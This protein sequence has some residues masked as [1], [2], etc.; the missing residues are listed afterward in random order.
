MEIVQV[1]SEAKSLNRAFDVLL[2]VRGRVGDHSL[3]PKGDK[4]TFRGNYCKR[5]IPYTN[6][7]TKCMQLTENLVTNVVLPDEVAKELL[8]HTGLVDHLCIQ[9]ERLEVSVENK[10]CMLTAVSQKV[11]PSSSAFSKTG[12]ASSRLKLL[13]KPKLKP[14]A[15]KPGDGT[16]RSPKGSV[17][18]IF[19]VV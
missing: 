3:T 2:D 19:A 17:L 13:P 18:T 8:I 6:E 7:N 16:V 5:L 11:H 15:P 9:C 12:S 14:I 4:A 10:R 1:R